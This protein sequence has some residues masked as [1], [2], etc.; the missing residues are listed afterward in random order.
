MEVRILPSAENDLRKGY[1]FYENQCLGL[2]GYFYN[3]LYHEIGSLQRIAGI[4]SKRGKL[5]R[6]KTKKF[7]YVIYY[8]IVD[9]VVYVRAILDVRQNSVAIQQ[10]EA[11]EGRL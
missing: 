10:R 3:S 7:P 2:G 11:E 4:H 6:M 1:H 5:F 9:S 8:Q